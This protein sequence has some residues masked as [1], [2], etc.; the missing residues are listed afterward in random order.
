MADE[1][2]GRDG[3]DEGAQGDVAPAPLPRSAEGESDEVD[4]EFRVIQETIGRLLRQ[5]MR[6]VRQEIR[7]EFHVGPLPH[8]K[9]LEGYERI[10]PG[11]ANM[12]FTEFERQGRHRRELERYTIVW[13]NYRSFAGLVCGL[14][15]TLSFLIVSYL[16]IKGGHGWEGTVL[17]SIDLVGLVAVFV[18]GSTV[19]RDERVRKSKLMGGQEDEF[20]NA[21]QEPRQQRRG[22]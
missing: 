16:L 14:I 22:E 4:A 9:T 15:V 20:G 12:I 7:S 8:E 21:N 18:Y 5:E 13:G 2:D 11:S 17:G 6:V 19:L 10:V 3:Q 1:P